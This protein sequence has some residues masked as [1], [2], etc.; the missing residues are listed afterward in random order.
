MIV[1]EPIL[2]PVAKP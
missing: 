1:P 2:F